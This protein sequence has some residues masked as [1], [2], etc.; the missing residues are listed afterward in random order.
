MTKVTQYVRAVHSTEEL[1]ELFGYVAENG[2]QILGTYSLTAGQG[3][4]VKFQLPNDEGS[5]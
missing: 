2:G 5:S 3:I 4:S 1:T